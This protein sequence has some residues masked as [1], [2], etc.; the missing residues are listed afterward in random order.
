M[1]VVTMLEER[2]GTIL[3]RLGLSAAHRPGGVTAVRTDTSVVLITCFEQD[4]DPWCRVSALV[5]SDLEPSL[6][7]LHRVHELNDD[8]LL[9]AFRLFQDRT[10][11]FTATLHGDHV[12]H[13]ALER[14]LRYVAHIADLHGPELQQLVGGRIGSQ[15]LHGGP[16]CSP[17]SPSP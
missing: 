17:S 4:D 11:A 9:G 14:T 8:V 13:D 1:D 5:L 10:L 3:G 6:E 12:D 15:L 7:L 2:V 16:P